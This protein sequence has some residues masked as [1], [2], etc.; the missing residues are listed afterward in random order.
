MLYKGLFIFQV[1]PT[2]KGDKLGVVRLGGHREGRETA[3]Q[4][5]IRE[6]H[7]ESSMNI[8]LISAPVTYYKN[9]WNEPSSKIHI[10]EKIAPILIKGSDSYTSNAMYLAYSETEPVPSSETK[11]LLLLTP[12]DIFKICDVQLTLK[13][14][15]DQNGKAQLSE[16]MDAGLYIEPFP[17]LMFLRELFISEPEMMRDFL[18]GYRANHSS[19]KIL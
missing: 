9:G 10:E 18:D 1:G 4:T 16:D 5:A 19:G 3:V 6:V 2:R 7:E 13:D 12:E 17:Q 14:Y 8:D 15:L 11:G